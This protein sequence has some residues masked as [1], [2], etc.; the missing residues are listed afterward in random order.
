MYKRKK[1]KLDSAVNYKLVHW[2]LFLIVVCNG[3][4]IWKFE[5][6]RK[7]RII[8]ETVTV[9]TN[10]VHVVT[11]FVSSS[12]M[13]LGTNGVPINGESS[14]SRPNDPQFEIE[15]PYR[16]LYVCGKRMIELGGR[17]F[18]EGSPTSYGVISRIFP[19][20]VLL[21]NGYF[22]KCQ[23]FAER[24]SYDDHP[25]RVND[26]DRRAEIVDQPSVVVRHSYSQDGS[27]NKGY[28]YE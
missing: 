16:Y 2:A 4:L 24:W 3:L 1:I 21:E 9:V 10:T 25:N 22:L 5:V 23:G 17:Y 15:I 13:N 14:V 8:R 28:Y 18:S 6:D 20:R 12:G 26:P 11:N 19:E 7:P 27:Y